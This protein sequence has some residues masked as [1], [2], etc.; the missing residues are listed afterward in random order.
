MEGGSNHFHGRRFSN[1]FQVGADNTENS[2]V[3]F[4]YENIM[5]RL[6]YPIHSLLPSSKQLSSNHQQDRR[7]IYIKN[8]IDE[9]HM[10]WHL[11]LQP[12]M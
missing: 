7:M 2:V 6:S 3:H 1:G 5:T 9:H 11:Q 4:L 10:D 12:T 8:I